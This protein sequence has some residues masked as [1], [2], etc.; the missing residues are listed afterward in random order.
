MIWFGCLA[1]SNGLRTDCAVQI[2][3]SNT[4]SKLPADP[5]LL[6]LLLLLFHFIFFSHC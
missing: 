4:Y 3:V 1:V 6:L 2:Q 5:V